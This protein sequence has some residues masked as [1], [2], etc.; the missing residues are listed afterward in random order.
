MNN[1]AFT[2]TFNSLN[3]HISDITGIFIYL[4]EQCKCPGVF[5]TILEAYVSAPKKFWN[6]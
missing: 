5:R 6:F 4:K 2:I 3:D 1:S